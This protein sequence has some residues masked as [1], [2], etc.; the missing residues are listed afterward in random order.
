MT[1]IIY[2]TIGSRSN[3]CIS[4]RRPFSLGLLSNRYLVMTRT[5]WQ[6]LSNES[7]WLE[8]SIRPL[9]GAQIFA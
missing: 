3:F 4:F 2:L 6:N 5:G 9:D 1:I 8:H 7:K